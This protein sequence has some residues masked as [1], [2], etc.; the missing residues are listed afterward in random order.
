MGVVYLAQQE[1]PVRRRVAL[2]MM[3]PGL[4][5]KELIA[6]FESEREAASRMDHPNIATYLRVAPTLWG[7]RST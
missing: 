3:R 6:R 5:N 2:K 7:G 4:E 1:K